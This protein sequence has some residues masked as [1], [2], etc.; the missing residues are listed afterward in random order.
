[1]SYAAQAAQAR[2]LIADK[3]TVAVWQVNGATVDPDEPWVQTSTNVDEYDVSIVL[4]PFDSTTMR[5]LGYSDR[6]EVPQ[7]TVAG[8]MGGQ[9]AFTPSL[10]D[11]VVVGSTT[12]SVEAVDRIAP[13][14]ATDILYV[15]ELRQ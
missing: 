6:Q 15:M 8:Y 7:G 1:V 4:L 13:D 12:Y 5:M 11:T 10:K 9:T 14:G 2:T 3:G